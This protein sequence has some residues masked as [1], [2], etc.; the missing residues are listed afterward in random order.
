MLIITDNE[1]FWSYFPES[2]NE[3]SLDQILEIREARAEGLDKSEM[4]VKFMQICMTDEAYVEMIE[5][6]SVDFLAETATRIFERFEESESFLDIQKVPVLSLGDT[7]LVGPQDY[8]QNICFGQYV[9]ADYQ[10]LL[11]Y[12]TQNEIHLDKLIAVL[13]RPRDELKYNNAINDRLERKIKKLEP[14]IKAVIHAFWIGC[15]LFL[16]KRFKAVFPKKSADG[17][18]EK[19]LTFAQIK[20]SKAAYNAKMIQYAK[21]PERKIEIYLENVYLVFEFIDYDVEQYLLNHKP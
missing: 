4:A 18:L 11:Y 21:T 10:Y 15:R 12:K 1:E 13:Y 19:E 2:L 6:C 14:E 3:C 8:I 9:E 5:L 20:A 17:K 7:E 16:S